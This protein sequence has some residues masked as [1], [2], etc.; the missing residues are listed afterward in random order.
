MNKDDITG[1]INNQTNRNIEKLKSLLW[2]CL[3]FRLIIPTSSS[4]TNSSRIGGYPPTLEEKWLKLNDCSLLFIG[5]ISLNQIRNIDNVLPPMGNLYFFITIDDIGYRYPDREGEFK[6]VYSEENLA[7]ADCDE[8]FQTI[9]EYSIS[10]LEKYTFPSYQ[11]H[12]IVQN[13]LIPEDINF[14]EEVEY[15]VSTLINENY[16]FGH[17]IFGHPKAMQGTVRF[18]WAMKYLGYEDVTKL[19]DIERLKINNEEENFLLLLQ[20]DFSDPKIEINNFGDAFAYFGIHKNDL[21]NR[22]FE[23]VVLVM[24]DT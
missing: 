2:P 20:I 8:N 11:E 18:W 5:Q 17:Q 1:L 6:V 14:I 22:N 3:T 21:Q 24:Q 9:K 12:L 7:K 23:K 13:D 16:L 10:F 15:E 4:K 19:S